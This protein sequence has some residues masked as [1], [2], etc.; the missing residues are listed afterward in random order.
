MSTINQYNLSNNLKD[1]NEKINNGSISHVENEDNLINNRQNIF[2]EDS[3]M[4]LLM[5][6][7]FKNPLNE[8]KQ[9]KEFEEDFDN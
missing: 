4:N 7:P 3:N 8:I 9:V 2:E 5:K 6:N 1:N